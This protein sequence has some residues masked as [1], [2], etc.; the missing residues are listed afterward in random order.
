[1]N[2]NSLSAS[3]L[4]HINGLRALAIIGVLFYHLSASYCPAGYFGVDL[5]LV[6]SGFLLFRSLLKPGA[7][8]NFQYGSYLL[9]KA[10]RILPSW[11]VVALAS[12][13]VAYFLLPNSERI[14][15]IIKTARTS[16][17]FYADFHIDASG[18]YFDPY[19]QQNPLLHF[20]YMSITQQLYI[21]AP[22][23]VIPLAKF[24]SRRAAMVLLGVLGV[25][26]LIYYIL[27]TSL[28]LLPE[29]LRLNML[30]ATGCKTAYYHLITRFW[31]IAAGF[32]V[33]LLPEFVS[34]PRLRALLSLLGF[35]GII[36]SFYLYS[37]GSPAVY[38]TVV[39]SLL[40]L[41]YSTSGPI[42]WLLSLKPVQAIGTISFSLYLWHWPIMVFW[43]YY[44]MDA[45]SPW[46]EVGMVLLSLLLGTL[47]WWG[48]ES[49]RTPSKPGW[50]GTLLRSSLLL[51]IPIALLAASK[52]NKHVRRYGTPAA[53]LDI[54]RN[55]PVAAFKLSDA[56]EQAR[57]ISPEERKGLEKL[58]E[59]GMPQIPLHMGKPDK[60]A[61]FLLMGDSYAVHLHNALHEACLREGEHG[62]FLFN[63][64]IPYWYLEQPK[65]LP[66]QNCWNEAIANTLLEYVKAHPDI[67]YILLNQQWRGRL[68]DI[69]S[70]IDWRTGKSVKQGEER[71]KIASEGL[72][73]FCKRFRE[74]GVEVILLGC[75]PY[76]SDPAPYDEWQRCR[77]LRKEYKERIITRERFEEYS[78]CALDLHQKL[79]D[80]GL[81]HYIKLDPA[82]MVNGEYPARIDEEFMY[83]DCGHLTLAGSRR[84]VDLL[85]PQLRELLHREGKPQQEP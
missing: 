1:M 12:C 10:W 84:V 31:E 20:W 3:Y 5:F 39:S 72:A 16:A 42:A 11:F 81:A 61:S 85:M 53:A 6:I 69:G 44:T 4:P 73:E 18:D 68:V 37:T 7:E 13:V 66:D 28:T 19:T 34:R 60:P 67:R 17:L 75:T 51:L 45:P 83:I 9:K 55:I 78:R 29:T 35:A 79:A 38:L 50:R 26:S 80:E 77:I 33:F 25:L 58:P 56:E 47:S 8:L 54:N 30:E 57:R 14:C 71:L 46:D 49:L 32:G 74:A 2:A 62:I 65:R 43:K 52:A 63:S 82:L 64:M 24:C 36:A 76:F 48:I 70:G 59:L 27:T 15:P 41:R 23:L 21:I 40:A 22:L